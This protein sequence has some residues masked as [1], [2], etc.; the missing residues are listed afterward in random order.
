MSKPEPDAS[1]SVGLGTRAS[2]GGILSDS[3]VALVA[4]L[5]QLLQDLATCERESLRILGLLGARIQSEV[6][7]QARFDRGCARAVGA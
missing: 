5:A 4:P 7:A 3:T 1:T 6:V 2:N